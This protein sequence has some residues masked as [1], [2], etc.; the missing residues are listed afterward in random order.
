MT[1][2]SPSVSLYAALIGLGLAFS[3]LLPAA[4][5]AMP[6]K[7][8][9][10]SQATQSVQSAVDRKT[11]DQGVDKRK[12]IVSEA[13]TAIK[14]TR[15]ALQALEQGK[16][17]DALKA[18]EIA[19]GKLELLIARDPKLA[20][21]PVDI[22]VFTQD[23]FA[24]PKTVKAVI[25][26]VKDLLD[27]GRV[28]AARRL[29]A[30]LASEIRFSITSI[31]LG[32]YPEAIKAIS[33]LIDQGKID[34]AKQALQAALGTLVIS[35]EIL[36]LPLLRADALL[37]EAERLAGKEKRSEEENRSLEEMLEAARQ[38]LELGEALGY[39]NRDAFKPLYEQIDQIEEK[40]S[41]GKSGSGWF[42]RIRKQIAELF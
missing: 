3:P 22:A 4:E 30:G 11:T 19:T 9:T 27:D 26:E 10:Q 16:R 40:S 1:R 18:L 35:D 8:Q 6:D 31:P 2:R 42:D 20:L 15:H 17:D 21:A 24:E 5:S 36:P 32:S 41:G 39:G 33:P 34:E 14:E 23:L 7:P 28:Q 13:V 29:M 25:G 12:R 38:Q 37:V